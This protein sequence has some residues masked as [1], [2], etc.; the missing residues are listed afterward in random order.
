MMRYGIC[1]RSFIAAALILSMTLYCSRDRSSDRSSELADRLEKLRSVPYTSVTPEEASPDTSGVTIS[2]RSRAWPG[3]NLYCSRTAPVALLVDMEGRVVHTWTYEHDDYKL[4][5]HAI[6]LGNG[7]IV[8]LNKFKYIFELDWNSNLIWEKRAEVHHEISKAGDGT[9]FVIEYGAEQYR[10]LRVR[11][12]N[13]VHMDARGE[14]L[15]RWSTYGHLDDLK[16]VLD[17][18]SFLDT[19]LDL[20]E[21]HGTSP[22][23]ES[24][25]EKM[26]YDYFHLNTVTIMPET[27]L[28]E[29][30]ARFA[31]GNLLICL[32]NVNQI[33][34]LDWDMAEILWGWGEGVLEWPHHPTMLENGNVLVFDNGVVRRYSRALEIDPASETIVWEYKANPPGSFF[35]REKGSAQRLPNGNTLICEGDKGRAFEVT[36]EGEIVWEWYNPLL[37]NGH[38]V[39]VYR[40]TRYPVEMVEPL[41]NR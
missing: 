35:T 31:T 33:A 29:R 26:T 22:G 23:R 11:F 10:G 19:T 34:V 20:K 38:R 12:D 18:T 41:L 28:G 30:D 16:R 13:I 6:L 2:D 7:D 3:Y 17:R 1:I 9:Y 8:A 36:G 40:F 14:E 37:E 21:E 5:D 24:F 39:Q 27:P 15:G 25:G 32:R 4:W